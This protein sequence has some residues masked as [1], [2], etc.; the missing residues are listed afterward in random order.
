M[1]GKDVG[2]RKNIKPNSHILNL[3]MTDVWYL[4]YDMAGKNEYCCGLE[5][6]KE[7]KWYH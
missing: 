5:R 3:G 4:I 1:I 2:D 7:C 6:G